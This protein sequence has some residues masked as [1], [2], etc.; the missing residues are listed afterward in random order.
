MLLG[1]SNGHVDV[2]RELLAAGCA[3]A[4]RQGGE[5]FGRGDWGRFG[6]VLRVGW[7]PWRAA[8]MKGGL[9]ISHL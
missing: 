9:F 1:A 6:Q 5:R 7:L 2:V 3:K 4:R 8:E